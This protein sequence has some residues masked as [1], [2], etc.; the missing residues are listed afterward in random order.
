MVS[1]REKKA[2]KQQAGALKLLEHFGLPA[3]D[4]KV[5]KILQGVQKGTEQL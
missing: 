5:Q 2:K 3:E 4:P 1:V